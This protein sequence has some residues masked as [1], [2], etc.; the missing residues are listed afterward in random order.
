MTKPK[1]AESAAR[2]A[3]QNDVAVRDARIA[4]LQAKL[5]AADKAPGDGACRCRG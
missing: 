1:L 4:E 5:A 2:N 3:A